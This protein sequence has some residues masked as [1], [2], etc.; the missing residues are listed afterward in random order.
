MDKELNMTEQLTH[1]VTVIRGCQVMEKKEE[2]AGVIA[3]G[4]GFI[5]GVVKMFWK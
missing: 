1:I 3:G 2:V 4:I 5:W